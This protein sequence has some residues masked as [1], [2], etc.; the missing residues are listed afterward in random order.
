MNISQPKLCYCELKP[1]AQTKQKPTLD[2]VISISQ[3]IAP[4]SIFFG[5][6]SH[7]IIW[8]CLRS[9]TLPSYILF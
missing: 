2:R 1:K 4:V 8:F 6:N 3:K 5:Q 9:P 7:E